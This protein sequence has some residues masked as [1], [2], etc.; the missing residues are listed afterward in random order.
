MLNTSAFDVSRNNV[1]S[2]VTLNGVESVV[3]D[4]QRTKGVEAA[5]DSKLNDQWH[6]LANVTYQD[7]VITDNPQGITSVGNHPQAAPAVI[8]NLWTSY[9]FSI[10]GISGFHI[11]GG[12]NYQGKSYSDI[13][14]VNSI[15]AY[16]IANAAFGYAA[17]HW[18]ID[19]NIHNI[20]NERYFLAANAAGALVGEP[21][22]AMV[23]V[24]PSF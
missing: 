7:A 6:V 24:H 3:F 15:P 19:V 5:L 10:A 20:T 17:K 18:G 9:L 8:A 22:S 11:G 12:L 2:A 23:T 16:L 1:A 4:S 14:N 21:G 13:T